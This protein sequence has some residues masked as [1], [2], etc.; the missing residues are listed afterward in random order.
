[1]NFSELVKKRQSVRKYSDKPVPKDILERCLEAARLAPSACNS[2][3]WSFIVIDDVK[4][5][6]EVAR[7]AFSGIYSSN[8]F[9]K[10]A[11]VLVAVI[12]EQSK[13]IAALGGYFRGTQYNLIDVGIAVEHFVLQAAEEGLGTCWLGFFNEKEVKKILN[14]PKEKKVDIMISVGY[15]AD[16][17]VREKSRRPIDEI[18]KYAQKG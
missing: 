16:D 15:P 2:Q 3:P 5:N 7:A 11:P 8:S 14:V 18:R 9:A 12:T 6:N 17:K 13:F 4:S 10:S 1:M